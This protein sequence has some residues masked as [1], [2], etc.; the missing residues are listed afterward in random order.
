MVT[1][2]S[3]LQGKKVIFSELACLRKDG[4]VF[5]SDISGSGTI[6][7]G[8]RCIMGFFTD[9]TER[10]WA[11]E[12]LRESEE[13]YRELFEKS[14]QGIL[15]IDVKTKRFLYGNPSICQML[16]YSNLEMQM[17]GIEDIHT[18][19]T[20]DFIM[21]NTGSLFQGEKVFFPAIHCLRKD[22]SAFYADISSSI[23]NTHEKKYTLNFFTDVTERKQAEERLEV[24]KNHLENLVQERTK[25]LQDSE[26]KFKAIADYTNDWESWFDSNGKLA[27]ISPSVE[28]FTGY[29]V[30]ECLSMP[31]YPMPIVM[32]ED[33][34]KSK[35]ILIES[36]SE[37]T[38]GSNFEFKI[39]KKNGSCR[40]I[41]RSWGPIYDNL[42]Q[43]M[44]IRSSM[45]DITDIKNAEDEILRLN[46]HITKLQE[47]ERQKVSKDL[48]DSVGQTILTAKLNIDTYIKNPQKYKRQLHV[49][50][51][52]IEKAIA[53]LREIYTNLYPA[54]LSDLGL[55]STI[56]WLAKNSLESN[57]IAVQ[58]SIN[59]PRKLNH[60]LEISLYR[61]IQ[62]IFSNI[63]KH[64]HADMVE[65]S[66]SNLNQT[67]ELVVKDNGVGFNP[68]EK[69]GAISGYGI[70]N[71]QSRVNSF[72]GNMTIGRDETYGTIIS[73]SIL[74]NTIKE[75]YNEDS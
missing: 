1:S 61:I 6:I 27:W 66:L 8:K 62:E 22:G 23:I 39:L 15:I 47:E 70:A 3:L 11:E 12:A 9:V 45:H 71:I 10:K 74:V 43:Y 73:I 7:N 32:K 30:E 31:D 38:A 28:Y 34:M 59:I 44:G 35:K 75:N 2:E 25:D 53:E 26:K 56:R 52:F 63:L 68:E 67:I 24:Y 72:R 42:G 54:I 5:Y 29:T 21:S 33:Q 4:T 60:D 36:I 17:L 14:M 57:H 65:L 51:T 19:D 16:G 58:L 13:K 64:S 50:V 37:R 46:Q 48:H 69:R 18:K 40:W 49:G 41:S 55:E 20:F